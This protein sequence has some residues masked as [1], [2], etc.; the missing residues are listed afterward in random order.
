MK[1]EMSDDEFI[2]YCELHAETDRAL[3]Q[4]KHVNRMLELAG[5][6]NGY[7]KSIKEDQF[8][9]LHEAM[10]ELCRLAR[11]VQKQP[12]GPK[13]LPPLPEGFNGTNVVDLRN[14]HAYKRN[15]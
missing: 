15:R 4:G 1:T 12:H 6:P 3:F 7:P 14:A 11:L 2:V 13:P 8:V 5:F 9:S 10:T